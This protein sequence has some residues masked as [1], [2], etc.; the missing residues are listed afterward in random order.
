MKGGLKFVFGIGYALVAS[1]LAL[2]LYWAIVTCIVCGKD[3]LGLLFELR[4]FGLHAAEGVVVMLVMEH[5][6][7]YKRV[8]EARLASSTDTKLSVWSRRPRLAYLGSWALALWYVLFTDIAA[9]VFCKR[10][11]ITK[12]SLG[13]ATFVAVTWGLVATGL[14]CAWSILLV[15]CYYFGNA[16]YRESTGKIN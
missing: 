8:G 15:M 10:E 9:V 7:A 12:E 3:M 1:E 4:L 2:A 14:T 6:N 16:A 13:M 5:Y 11:E